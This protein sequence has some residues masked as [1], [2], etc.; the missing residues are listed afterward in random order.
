MNENTILCQQY[1]FHGKRLGVSCGRSDSGH[2]SE[3]QSVRKDETITNVK[4][5]II[6]SS[7][8]SN[9]YVRY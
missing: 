4:S 6:G 5:H 3:K 8:N 7:I 2:K 9:S 1:L